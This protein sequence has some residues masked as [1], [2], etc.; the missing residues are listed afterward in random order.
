MRIGLPLLIEPY[1]IEMRWLFVA[2]HPFGY[3]LI[4]PYGIEIASRKASR[5]FL[6]N[7]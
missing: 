6:I 1:G 4:E 3:L 7:F 5:H 2:L